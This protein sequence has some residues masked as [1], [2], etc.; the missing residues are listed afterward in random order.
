M[1]N[2]ALRSS[3]C[4]SRS[5]LGSSRKLSS[6]RMCFSLTTLKPAFSAS[7]KSDP[8]GA[9]KIVTAYWLGSSAIAPRSAT[10]PA[11]AIKRVT[12]TATRRTLETVRIRRDGGGGA[13]RGQL[14]EAWE[15]GGQV[16]AH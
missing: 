1:S 3:P 6:G 12:T 15:E 10:P 2:S 4:S 11:P 14:R 13:R 16:V 8:P 5:A 7:A 9:E